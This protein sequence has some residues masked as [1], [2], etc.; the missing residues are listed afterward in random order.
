[1]VIYGATSS[2]IAAAIQC[3]RLSKTVLLI[4]PTNR[5]GGLTTGGLGATNIGNKNAI[6]GISREFY[7]NIKNYYSDP[8]HWKWQDMAI[9]SESRNNKDREDAM[10][11]FEPSVALQIYN[12]MMANESIDL[13]YR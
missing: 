3:S 4:K 8:L 11:T 10:W 12:E 6:G 7:Q 2:G 9:Y 5:I 13:V 1:M